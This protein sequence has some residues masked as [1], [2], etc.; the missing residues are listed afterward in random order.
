M[1][2]RITKEIVDLQ[3]IEKMQFLQGLHTDPAKFS[4]YVNDKSNRILSETIDAKRASFIKVSSD[5]ARMM[6]MNHNSLATLKRTNELLDT[7]TKI[8]NE[9]EKQKNSRTYNKDLTRRQVEVNNWY[10]ENKRE[11]LFL[12]QFLLLVVLSVVVILYMAYNGWITQDAADYLIWFIVIAGVATWAYRW[13]YTNKL[14]D[15]R[16]WSKR[17][18]EGDG[19]FARSGCPGE[20]KPN[21]INP[22][23]PNGKVFDQKT[24][25]CLALVQTSLGDPSEPLCP[26]GTKYSKEMG[27]C[28]APV[29][30]SCA[31]VKK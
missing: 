4:A 3:D 21:P 23:C 19:S 7:D 9:Q 20:D 11:T 8:F 5:M 22:T 28:A 30:A 15:A 25:M 1:T 24:G 13:Y 26:T 27:L 17:R 6:D 29:A 10:Y 18:F 31:T 12:L 2:E 16:Y 14:R